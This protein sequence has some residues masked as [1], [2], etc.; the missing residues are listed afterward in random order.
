[1]QTIRFLKSVIYGV[2]LFKVRDVG[3]NEGLLILNSEFVH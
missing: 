1:M 2:F 3:G